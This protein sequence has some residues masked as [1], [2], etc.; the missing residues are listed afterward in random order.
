MIKGQ[1]GSVTD[2]PPSPAISPSAT[3]SPAARNEA[4]EAPPARSD[5]TTVF[6]IVAA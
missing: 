1:L 3:L 4:R 5:D 2:N 6:R